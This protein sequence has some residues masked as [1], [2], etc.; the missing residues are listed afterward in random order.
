LQLGVTGA[1]Y[2]YQ[3]HTQL[4][5]LPLDHIG[6]FINALIISY[7]LS[8]TGFWNIKLVARTGPGISYR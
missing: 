2:I 7:A 8:H 5:K 6:N 1:V 4:Q 3:L